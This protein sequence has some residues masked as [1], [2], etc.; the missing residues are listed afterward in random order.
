MYCFIYSIL[1]GLQFWNTFFLRKLPRLLRKRERFWDQDYLLS[2]FS[3]NSDEGV[4]HQVLFVSSFSIYMI[5]CSPRSGRVFSGSKIWPKCGVGFGK[6]QNIFTGNGIWLL[7]RS[8]IRHQNLGTGCR[9]F[10][11]V[12]REFGTYVLAENAKSN[13]Q[14][15]SGVSFESKLESFSYIKFKIPA[16]F[17]I[18]F[19]SNRNRNMVSEVF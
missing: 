9:I 4:Q 7:P 16:T 5:S 18:V 11:P 1:A 6:M 13:R 12:W 3:G 8:G 2:W 15:F 19:L 14:A 17:V 10:L